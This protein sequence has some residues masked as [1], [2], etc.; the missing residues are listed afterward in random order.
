[1]WMPLPRIREG[2]QEGPFVFRTCLHGKPFCEECC[3]IDN[4][5][6]GAF[7]EIRMK[8]NED[9]RQARKAGRRARKR[10]KTASEVAYRIAQDTHLRICERDS[11]IKRIKML[12]DMGH[13]PESRDGGG[14]SSGD[15]ARTR[16]KNATM[17]QFSDSD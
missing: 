1:M 4:H 8:I 13:A 11:I 17:M 12:K 16:T 15:L 6:H 5:N 9:K 3:Y 2:I 14:Y 10:Q 7:T